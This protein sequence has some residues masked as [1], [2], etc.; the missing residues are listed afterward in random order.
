MLD[1]MEDPFDNYDRLKISATI[2]DEDAKF[3]HLQQVNL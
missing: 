1:E 2:L 3:E